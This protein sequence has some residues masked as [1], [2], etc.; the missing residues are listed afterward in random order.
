MEPGTT[1]LGA[2]VLKK[3]YVYFDSRDKDATKIGIGL[4]NP[5]FT[6]PAAKS[7]SGGFWETISIL[8]LIMLAIAF[9]VIICKRQNLIKVKAMDL[10]DLKRGK[11]TAT[12]KTVSDIKSESTSVYTDL[13]QLNGLN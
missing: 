9:C 13:S 12:F 6:S 2:E 1:I 10:G 3:Y 7:S 5:D 11:S 4:K 8:L